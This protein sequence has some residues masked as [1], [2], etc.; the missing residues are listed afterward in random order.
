MPTTF[1][2]IIPSEQHDKKDIKFI[3]E[4][5]ANNSKPK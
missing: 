5:E 3:K 4:Q 1:I 2:N